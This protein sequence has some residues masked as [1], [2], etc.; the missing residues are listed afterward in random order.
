MMGL[1]YSPYHALQAVTWANELDLG[2]SRYKKTPFKWEK[3]VKNIP[4]TSP[5]DC[6]LPWVYKESSN[7][8]IADDLFVYVDYG[9][10]I[11]TTKE[12]CWETSRK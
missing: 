1:N 2:N 7:R 8:S 11:G 5:Y 12:L 3:L 6:C 10:K 4:G 9:R